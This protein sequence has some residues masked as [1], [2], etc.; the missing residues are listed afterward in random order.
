MTAFIASPLSR[1]FTPVARP[2]INSR[3]GKKRCASRRMQPR[4]ALLD[5][6]GLVLAE[7]IYGEIARGGFGIILSGIGGAFIAA[8]II[9]SNY[10]EVR[11]CNYTTLHYIRETNLS[12]QIE[13]NFQARNDKLD[14]SDDI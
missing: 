11:T 12:T 8:I 1:A 4:A 5:P 10:D 3:A 2:S 13:K 6:S 7:D 14:I 9:R